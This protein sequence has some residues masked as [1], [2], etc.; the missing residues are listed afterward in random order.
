M[1]AKNTE[2]AAQQLS[3]IVLVDLIA[4]LGDFSPMCRCHLSLYKEKVLIHYISRVYLYKSMVLLLVKQ[5]V[6]R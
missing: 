5:H 2:M 3:C 6:L 1:S 4:K